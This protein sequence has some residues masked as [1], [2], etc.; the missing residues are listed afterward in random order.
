L[1]LRDA[2]AALPGLKDAARAAIDAVNFNPA[3]IASALRTV[4]AVFPHTALQ[5][6]VS[7]LGTKHRS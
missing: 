6:G 3:L 4:L 1:L 2:G 7:T 5:S